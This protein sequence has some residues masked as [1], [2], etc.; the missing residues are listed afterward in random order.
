MPWRTA[1]PSASITACGALKSVSATHIGSGSAA[2]SSG[3]SSL[4]AKAHFIELLEVRS[5]TSSKTDV[6]GSVGAAVVMRGLLLAVAAWPVCV[7]RKGYQQAIMNRN[8]MISSTHERGA[9]D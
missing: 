3:A 4:S 5:I 9:Y 2:A 7:L 8:G 6:R 1:S